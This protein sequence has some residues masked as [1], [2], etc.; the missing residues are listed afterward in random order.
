MVSGKPRRIRLGATHQITLDDV[1]GDSIEV[2]GT[3]GEASI[4]VGAVE[5]RNLSMQPTLPM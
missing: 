1:R 5:G 2:Y 4:V 3:T